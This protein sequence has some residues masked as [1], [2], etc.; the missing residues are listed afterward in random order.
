MSIQPALRY[1][2]RSDKVFGFQ[3]LT[4]NRLP[5]DDVANM[6]LVFMLRGNLSPWKQPIAYFLVSHSV[7]PET[8]KRLLR[9]ILCDIHDTGIEVRFFYSYVPH[10]YT[11]EENV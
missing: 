2:P 11:M 1:N 5:L 10:T 4:D 3:A 7:P 6:L 8:L 9:R